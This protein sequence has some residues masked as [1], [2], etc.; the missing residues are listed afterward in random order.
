MKGKEGKNTIKKT[1]VKGHV[2]WIIACVLAAF[3]LLI[4]ILPFIFMVL[5]SFKDK[6]EML[7]K[8]IFQ[9]PDKFNTTN[10]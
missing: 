2:S 3:W 6:F 10:Y 7:V 9:L 8:G 5:N 4:T 1:T